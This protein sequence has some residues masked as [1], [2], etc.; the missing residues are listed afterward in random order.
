MTKPSV[1]S[2]ELGHTEQTTAPPTDAIYALQTF[3]NNDPHHHGLS[4]Q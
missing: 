3:D 1:V 2:E 4:T